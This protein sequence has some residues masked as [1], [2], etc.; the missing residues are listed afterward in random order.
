MKTEE[1]IQEFRDSIDTQKSKFSGMTYE[2]GLEAAL[3]WVLDEA[4]ID[5]ADIYQ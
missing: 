3:A 5:K 2:Q 4:E 1:E